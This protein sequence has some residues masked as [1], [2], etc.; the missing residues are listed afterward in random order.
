MGHTQT[1]R[2]IHWIPNT[3]VHGKALPDQVTTVDRKTTSATAPQGG[4]PRR[5]IAA[6]AT[7]TVLVG[8]GAGLGGMALPLLLHF[9]QHL[10]FG[11]SRDTVIS[12]ESFL[13]GVS[14]STPMRRV[15]ALLICGAIA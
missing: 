5:A 7:V 4:R 12:P 6:L 10:A 2:A 8:I 15:S 1:K 11:Y 3:A 9:I 14:A 13:Q